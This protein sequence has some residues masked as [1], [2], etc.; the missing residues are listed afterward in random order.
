MNRDEAIQL[1][2]DK[3]YKITSQRKAILTYFFQEDGY[4]NAKDLLGYLNTVDDGISMDTVYRNLYLFDDLGILET[5]ELE[6]EKYFRLA[7]SKHHHHHFICQTCG[8][9][10]EISMCPMDDLNQSLKGYDVID[11]KFEVYGLCPA[12]Q[13]DAS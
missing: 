10:K 11:H 5:T 2:K 12:C 9:T 1:I 13:K 6:G 3:D 4:R 8:K 7:C